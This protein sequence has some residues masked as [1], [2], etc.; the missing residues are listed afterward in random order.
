M[1]ICFICNEYPP[2]THGGIGTFTQTMAR[3]LVS[4]GH[5]ATVVGIYPGTMHPVSENDE[6]VAVVRLP[7]A[8]ARF[9]GFLVGG[10]RIRRAL[11]SVHRRNP[12]DVVEGPE[13]SLAVVPR[14]F[15]AARVIR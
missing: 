13:T 14:T 9:M 15:P 11:D 4:S 5:M 1:H 6:G 7:H 8:A 3:A 2:E 12:V 10:I